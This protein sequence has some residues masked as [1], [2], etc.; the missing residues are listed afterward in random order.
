MLGA[1]RH[2]GLDFDH[3]FEGEDNLGLV[4]AWNGVA[5]EEGINILS[6]SEEVSIAVVV[7]VI[8]QLCVV[9]SLLLILL[10]LLLASCHLASLDGSCQISQ[11]LFGVPR[12]VVHPRLVDQIILL[13]HMLPIDHALTEDLDS[14]LV[15]GE[16][17]VL[18]G[19]LL[20]HAVKILIL[21][22]FLGKHP[23]SKGQ[24]VSQLYQLVAEL[25][26]LGALSEYVIE[27]IEDYIDPLLLV[28]VSKLDQSQ[29][30]SLI[31]FDNHEVGS[32]NGFEHF[33]DV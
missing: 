11:T 16:A 30:W 26:E 33:L 7:R 21:R 6:F 15:I 19:D 18:P 22:E 5:R 17:R 29:E 23:V 20:N 10:F 4:P 9:L 28:G 3:L 8:S 27:V 1:V 13:V 2:C 32:T 24:L 12:D 25:P 14:L 31:L